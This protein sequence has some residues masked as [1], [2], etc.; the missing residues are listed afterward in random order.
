MP[1][2]SIPYPGIVQQGRAFATKD[3]YLPGANIV[4]YYRAKALSG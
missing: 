2:G 3:Q 4:N 1:I